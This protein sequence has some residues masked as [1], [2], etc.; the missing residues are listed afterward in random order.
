MCTRPAWQETGRKRLRSRE[1]S[2]N[3]DASVR[4]IDHPPASDFVQQVRE[5]LR[6]LHDRTRLQTHLLARLASPQTDKRAPGRGKRLQDDLLQAIEALQPDS[7]VPADSAATRNY[8]ILARR[9]LDAL[10]TAEVQRQLAIGK[11]EYYA[12][13]QRAL[14]AVASLLW[15]RWQPERTEEPTPGQAHPLPA[16]QVVAAADPRRHNLPA[17]LTSFVGRD[18]ELTEVT[19][20]L[21]TTRLLTVTGVGG[22]GKTRLALQVAASLIGAYAGGIWFVELAPLVDPGLLSQT[23]AAVLGIVEQ[24]D[25][26]ILSTVLRV[27]RDQHVLLILDNCEHLIDACARVSEVV[28]RSCPGVRILATSREALGIGGELAWSLRS[29]ALPPAD[30]LSTHLSGDLALLGDFAAVQL[31]VERARAVDPS[32][33]LSRLNASPVIQI[34]RRVDGIPL[35]IELAAARVK[36]FSVERIAG[37]LDDLFRLLTGGS[38]TALPRQQTL[39]ATID[40]S[41]D[42]LG[43][44]ER[45]LFC[46]LSVFVGG[47]DYEAIERMCSDGDLETSRL[48]E[49]DSTQDI[50]ELVPLSDVPDLLTRLV[51]QSLVVVERGDGVERY[52]LLETIRQYGRDRLVDV[53]EAENIRNRHFDW[54]LA[55][56]ERAEPELIGPEQVAWLDR[57]EMDQDNFRAAL[58][59]GPDSRPAIEGLRLAAAL[60]RVWQVRD[61]ES[62]GMGW[63]SRALTAPEAQGATAVRAK[64]LSGVWELVVN[65]GGRVADAL[66]AAEESLAICQEIGDRVGAAWSM[67]MVGRAAS[68]QADYARAQEILDQALALARREQAPWVLGQVLEGLGV[69]AIVRD[70]PQLG[71]RNLEESLALFRELGDRRA[72]ASA[73]FWVGLNAGLLADYPAAQARLSEALGIWRE[74]GSRTSCGLVSLGLSAVARVQG[75]YQQSRTFLQES[76]AQARDIGSRWLN[77]WGL[78]FSGWSVRAEGDSLRA[79]SLTAEALRLS[80]ASVESAATTPCLRNLGILA[81]E[82][83]QVRRGVCLLGAADRTAELDE[84]LAQLLLDAIQAYQASKMTARAILGDREFEAAWAEGQAMTL[85]QAVAYALEDENGA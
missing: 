71:R 63:L 62:E 64:A 81:I 66:R 42:L 38:R 45:R 1:R 59:W 15:E 12:D 48:G 5:A 17:E 16:P 7:Q 39:R 37:R 83:G 58:A 18:R 32:F 6:Y 80:R 70:D 52:R 51:E 65:A 33:Q 31:F 84:P 60:W 43:E 30:W 10:E 4:P 19:G 41:Y 46:R 82:A 24:S 21:R 34:C 69:L 57:L 28:L 78:I 79:R 3:D 61:R 35:A 54:F 68:Y 77:E 74:V 36:V 2:L 72:I 8:Q 23:I 9:Y 73:C 27:L 25:E 56:A 85:D 40:W 14:E 11:T 55:L 22:T 20:L 49:A 75:N 29:L 67:N 47:C 13:H 53:R 50:R 26:P 76:L 44:R